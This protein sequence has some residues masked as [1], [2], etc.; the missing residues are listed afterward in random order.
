[1]AF[2]LTPKEDSFYELFGASAGHLVNAAKEKFRM[3]L[4]GLLFW[5]AA[6]ATAAR[7]AKPH[8]VWARLVYRKRWFSPHGDRK[9][10]RSK[11]RYAPG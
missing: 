5:P 11:A 7:L 8:S 1:M 9:L 6:V 2:R 3:A 10:E 4:V